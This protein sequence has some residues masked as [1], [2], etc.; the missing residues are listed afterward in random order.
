MKKIFGYI[1]TGLG[2][3]GILISLILIYMGTRPCSSD[4]CMIHLLAMLGEGLIIIALPLI[5]VGIW[6]L[7]LTRVQR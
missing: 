4:G 7:K 1:L 3:I 2:S 6:L 5:F